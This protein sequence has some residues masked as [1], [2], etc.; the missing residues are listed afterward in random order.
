MSGSQNESSVTQLV[1]QS[2]SSSAPRSVHSL[3]TSV[4]GSH[5]NGATVSMAFHTM[6]EVR[7]LVS[8]SSHAYW[9]ELEVVFV[10]QINLSEHVMH[11]TSAFCR[12][13]TAPSIASSLWE[14]PTCQFH[15]SGDA[16]G[17][18]QIFTMKLDLSQ[19]MTSPLIMPAPIELHRTGLAFHATFKNVGTVGDSLVTFSEPCLRVFIRG[20][21]QMGGQN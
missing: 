10:P 11:I 15:T 7:R 14:L 1:H 17:I 13:D 16:Q 21:V 18:P 9:T 3:F 12:D 2:L 4:N 19:S 6:P 20:K 8:L 5:V